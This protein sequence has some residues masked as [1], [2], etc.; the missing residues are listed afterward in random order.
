M[1]RFQYLTTSLNDH[2]ED[3]YSD[4]YYYPFTPHRKLIANSE[5]L[6]VL[7]PEEVE[8]GKI[9]N[10]EGDLKIDPTKLEPFQ[11]GYYYYPVQINYFF[12]KIFNFSE[13]GYDP[14]LLS[15]RASFPP[16]IVTYDRYVI[17]ELGYFD[18]FQ[19]LPQL[20]NRVNI[21]PF[22]LTKL[23]PSFKVTEPLTGFQPSTLPDGPSEYQNTV[24][25]YTNGYNPYN[26]DY[27][28]SNTNPDNL[29]TTDYL[30]DDIKW[31][32]T[33]SNTGFFGQAKN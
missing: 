33:T 8:Q 9:S 26:S 19:L 22:K 14:V 30:G 12:I 15:N 24:E 3:L 11:D 1:A 31:F 16:Y 7:T 29:F 28:D 32:K 5:Y 17:F 6:F 18:R 21:Q 4:E 10:Y 23:P 20:V 13:G 2:F 27:L 25:Q